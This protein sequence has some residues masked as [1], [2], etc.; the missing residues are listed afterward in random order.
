MEHDHPLVQ[1]TGRALKLPE[2]TWTALADLV[3]KYDKIAPGL[4]EYYRVAMG[5]YPTPDS[6]R[7]P[8]TSGPA[9]PDSRTQDLHLF[10]S[11]KC[12]WDSA[13]R[14]TGKHVLSASV[15]GWFGSLGT[16]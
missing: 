5:F 6:V 9:D 10:P 8:Y 2:S 1:E 4:G 12:A 13:V 7:P 3:K 14:K 11:T 16:R 15:L